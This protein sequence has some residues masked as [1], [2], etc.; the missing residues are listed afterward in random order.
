MYQIL[1]FLIPPS[2]GAPMVGQ[3]SNEQLQE[4]IRCI[5]KHL[6]LRFRDQYY[7]AEFIEQNPAKFLGFNWIDYDALSDYLRNEGHESL[8]VK[9]P[10][11]EAPIKHEDANINISLIVAAAVVRMLKLQI[12]MA[13]SSSSGCAAPIRKLKAQARS[14]SDPYPAIATVQTQLSSPQPLQTPMREPFSA[15]FLLFELAIANKQERGARILFARVLFF[16]DAPAEQ[17]YSEWL[18]H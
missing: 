4:L 1:L 10:S 16:E 8:L 12:K 3:E 5:P 14:I 7:N 13:E 17:I 9:D 15:P 18:L 6:L 11:T 2:P